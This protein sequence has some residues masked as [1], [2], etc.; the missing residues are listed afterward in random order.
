MIE[1]LFYYL[2]RYND[3]NNIFIIYISN[4][5][6][7]DLCRNMENIFYLKSYLED[8]SCT[9]VSYIILKN[10]L[11]LQFKYDKNF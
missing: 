3:K 9:F 8:K 6:I 7:S 10:H 5:N 2:H 1:K 11:H 4:Q